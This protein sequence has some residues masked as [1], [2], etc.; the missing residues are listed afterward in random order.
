MVKPKMT[1]T[2]KHIPSGEDWVILGIN[3]ERD[4]VCSATW[5]PSIAKFYDFTYLTERSHRSP[6]QQSYM[7]SVFGLDWN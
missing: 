5:P 7:E 1:Y 4:E 6:Y 3:E 2:A